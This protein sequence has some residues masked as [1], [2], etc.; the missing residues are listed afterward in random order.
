MDGIVTSFCLGGMHAG[1]TSSTSHAAASHT[2]PTFS[3]HA[4]CSGSPHR[5]SRPRS[6]HRPRRHARPRSEM[7]VSPFSNAHAVLVSPTHGNAMIVPRAWPR[8]S[9]TRQ[10]EALWPATERRIACYPIESYQAIADPC[11][12]PLCCPLH[13]KWFLAR[14]HATRHIGSFR[15]SSDTHILGANSRQTAPFLRKR[16]ITRRTTWCPS[17]WLHAL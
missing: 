2:L 9:P 7:G 10:R 15:A 3:G 16:C 1:C 5:A 8:G 13:R 12:G 11:T 17:S 14:V 4:A 6:R